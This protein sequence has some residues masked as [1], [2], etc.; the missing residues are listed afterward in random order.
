MD[1]IRF[2]LASRRFAL[3]LW[4]SLSTARGV[5]GGFAA[6]APAIDFA[7]DVQPS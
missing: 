7:R 3:A 2:Q 6:D 4:I 5:V 1:P